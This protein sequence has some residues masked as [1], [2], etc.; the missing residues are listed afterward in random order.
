MLLLNV[1]KIVQAS[2]DNF[3]ETA[4]GLSKGTKKLGGSFLAMGESLT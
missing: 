2:S 4:R 3:L 1:E